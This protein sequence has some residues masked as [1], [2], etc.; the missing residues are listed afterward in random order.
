MTRH[1]AEVIRNLKRARKG[2]RSITELMNIFNM[3]KTTVWHHVQDIPLGDAQKLELRQKQGGSRQ[4][5][6]NAWIKANVEAG[7]L[8]ANSSIR[9]L[10]VKATM[11][12]WAEGNKR[13]LVFTNTDPEILS[14]FV[15][16]LTRVLEVENERIR[17]LVRTS[18]PIKPDIVRKFWQER[19]KVPLPQ[20]KVNHDNKHNRTKSNNGICRLWVIK[21]GYEFKV[22][23][24]IIKHLKLLS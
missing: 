17:I 5:S 1:S 18:D 6:E 10:C 8:L 14:I 23:Q 12:Y 7:V 4:R 20:I 2:G 22:L 21:S 13:A 9:E 24:S 11:L 16:F 19:L 15:L 3:P